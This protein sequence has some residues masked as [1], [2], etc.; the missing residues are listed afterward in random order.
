MSLTG[1]GEGVGVLGIAVLVGG[2]GVIVLGTAVTLMRVAVGRAGRDTT[3]AAVGGAVGTT[4]SGVGGAGG[5]GGVSVGRACRCADSGAGLGGGAD[6]GFVVGV[7]VAGK[8]VGGITELVFV[9]G[10]GV[11][12]DVA[13][14][15]GGC[16]GVCV[17]PIG[18]L[19]D[20]GTAAPDTVT[21]T[22]PDLPATLAVFEIT[23]PFGVP[24][25][26]RT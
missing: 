9:G 12:G 15:V 14:F 4:G 6:V 25:L 26:T 23:V 10:I 18:V 8:G 20:V 2:N 7:D 11:T 22:L 17:D 1:A 19:V 13:V 3:G 24:D 21:F 5:G 16:T